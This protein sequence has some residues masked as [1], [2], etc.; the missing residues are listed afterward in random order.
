MPLPEQFV[1]TPD[2]YKALVYMATKA[3]QEMQKLVDAIDERHGV[4]RYRMWARWVT[5]GKQRYPTA[6]FP[7]EWPPK[8]ELLVEVVGRP[9]NKQDVLDQVRQITE[10]PLSLMVTKDMTKMLGWME[11]EEAF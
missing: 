8:E 7:K 9:V 6:R 4:R 1:L 5:P 2:E 10:A 3:S 11:L